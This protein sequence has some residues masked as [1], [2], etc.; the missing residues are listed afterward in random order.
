LRPKRAWGN[1]E[2]PRNNG[3]LGEVLFFFGT[4]TVPPRLKNRGF[5]LTTKR[6]GRSLGATC[7]RKKTKLF[8]L[9]PFIGLPWDSPK[10]N[11]NLLPGIS[12]DVATNT[13]E[14]QKPWF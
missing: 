9:V 4:E 11:Q 10:E 2:K 13:S 7:P 1:W 14:Q 12:W 6:G 3:A 5:A 8:E